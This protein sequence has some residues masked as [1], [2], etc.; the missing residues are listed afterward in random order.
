MEKLDI[1][2]YYGEGGTQVDLGNL[3][4]LEP[5]TDARIEAWFGTASQVA[6]HLEGEPGEPV[7]A[8]FIRETAGSDRVAYI[9]NL[10][11]PKT[12]RRRGSGKTLLRAMLKELGRLGVR[13]VFGAISP[14]STET[15]ILEKFYR[16]EG[17]EI[18][19]PMDRWPV[20]AKTIKP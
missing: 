15:A 13:H 18:L 1:S 5:E 8:Q 2:V 9:E 17:F 10:S 19:A 4:I 11:V 20:I 3:T 6:E 7:L 12:K 14:V 16:D